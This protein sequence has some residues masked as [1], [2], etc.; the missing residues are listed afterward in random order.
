MTWRHWVL[1][2]NFST[3]LLLLLAA[4]GAKELNALA[5]YALLSILT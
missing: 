2:Y 4:M 3:W 1:N 5:N